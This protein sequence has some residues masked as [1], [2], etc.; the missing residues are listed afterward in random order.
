MIIQSRYLTGMV[1]TAMGLSEGSRMDVRGRDII[2]IDDVIMSVLT[3]AVDEAVMQAPL[4]DVT[5]MASDMRD[6]DL[7]W[8]HISPGCCYG[9]IL[10][11]RDFM[12]LITF[13]MSGWERPVTELTPAD[14]LR[15][16]LAYCREPALQGT[17]QRPQCLLALRHGATVLEFR[18]CTSAGSFI[19][20]ARYLPHAKIDRHGGITVAEAC[21]DR[22]ILTAATLCRQI[23]D[24]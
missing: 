12:R 14:D 13:S 7:F 10:L 8:D 3:R 19:T 23:I 6:A 24:T 2:G 18:S 20:E 4:P 9:H 15:H 17:H 21:L 5:D 1:R 16:T 22:I 11:P